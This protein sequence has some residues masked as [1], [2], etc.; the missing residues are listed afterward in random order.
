MCTGLC[1]WL[2]CSCPADRRPPPPTLA[3]D[4]QEVL[5]A[6]EGVPLAEL[7]AA[8]AQLRDTGHRHITFSP[9]VFIPLTRLCR[10]R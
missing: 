1:A 9:K 6:A 5:A 3:L 8:A 7:M 4:L 10:D 2:D